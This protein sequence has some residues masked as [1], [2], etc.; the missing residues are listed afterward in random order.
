MDGPLRDALPA[1]DAPLAPNRRNHAYIERERSRLIEQANYFPTTVASDDAIGY[2][3]PRHWV[4]SS[5]ERFDLI[6]LNGIDML[7]ACLSRYSRPMCVRLMEAVTI[8]RR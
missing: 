4:E 6:V 5:D 2:I 7:S 1:V 3:V 8:G